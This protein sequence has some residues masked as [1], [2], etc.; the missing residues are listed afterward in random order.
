MMKHILFISIFLTASL[1]F[2]QNVEGFT[3]ISTSNVAIKNADHFALENGEAIQKVK[4]T[5][6]F[7]ISFKDSIL[8][9][10]PGAYKSKEGKKSMISQVYKIINIL[11]VQDNNGIDLFLITVKSGISGKTYEYYIEH[12][13]K[14][15][16][17]TQIYEMKGSK[18]A[19]YN[20]SGVRFD[21]LDFCLIRSYYR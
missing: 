14:E 13:G 5:N 9:H 19:G 11:N 21:G 12:N 1:I 3:V 2:G 20:Y 4:Q 15:V 8:I 10:T 16:R 6:T 18:E 17:L 7:N